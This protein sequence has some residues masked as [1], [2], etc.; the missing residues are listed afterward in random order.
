MKSSPQLMYKLSDLIAGL[1]VTIKGNPDCLISGVS[2]IQQAAAGHITFLTNALY[3]KHLATTQASAVIL[4]EA[5]ATECPINA[6][7]SRNPHYTYAKIA[8]F[9]ANEPIVE[10]TEIHPTAVI[11]KHCQIDPSAS[12]GA[13]T[14]IGNHV[15]I[16]AGAIIGPGCTIADGVEIGEDTQ[17]DAQVRIYHKVK[18]GKRTR[19]TSGAVI[20]SDGFGFANQKGVWH[21]VPQLGSV[22]IGDDVDIGANTTID[23]G[24]VEDTIIENGVKLDNLIQVGHNVRIGANTIIAGCVAI[25]GSTLIGKNCMIG[26][27]TSFAGHISICDN[28]MITGMSAV[29]KSIT[30][31][32]IYSSGIVGVVPN[33]EFKKNNARFHRLGNL[34]ERVK[35][36]E[37]SFKDLI[38]RKSS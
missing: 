26:G 27:Q 3:R 10:V 28:A 14:V 29:S 7:I 34:I 30:A 33:K 12:I 8:A 13:N 22:I 6:I 36:L 9:F 11:G 1:D 25:A 31:P 23:R 24:A 2:P 5:D 19:I 16:A 32:G 37:S 35:I 15:H 38:A 18:I 4:H 21:K 20:G 17:L